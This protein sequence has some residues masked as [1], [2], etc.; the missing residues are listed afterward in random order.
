MMSDG[1]DPAAPSR[2]R[3]PSRRA[4]VAIAIVALLAVIALIIRH[5]RALQ[6]AGE[7]A[8]STMA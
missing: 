5:G 8:G 7:P 4:L 2:R 1:P 3:M 6:S